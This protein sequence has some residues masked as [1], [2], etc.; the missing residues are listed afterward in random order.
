M[1][2][3]MSLR[4][5]DVIQDTPASYHSGGDEGPAPSLY[6]GLQNGCPG[7]N[8]THT[9]TSGKLAVLDKRTG[10]KPGLLCLFWP[11]VTWDLSSP[12]RDQTRTPALEGEVL[13]TGPP[14][15]FPLGRHFNP[16][17]LLSPR[18]R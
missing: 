13:T 5:S 16:P 6:A 3:M 12:A 7:D 11:Q 1:T 4:L 2:K 9:D 8:L 10:V 14:E 18:F 17:A 15:K